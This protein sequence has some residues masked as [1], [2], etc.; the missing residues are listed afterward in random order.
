MPALLIVLTGVM[1][2]AVL[3]ALVAVVVGKAFGALEG[4]L[5][6]RRPT[7]HAAAATAPAAS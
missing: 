6:E 2:W 1:A 4:D 3:A 7:P 5:T